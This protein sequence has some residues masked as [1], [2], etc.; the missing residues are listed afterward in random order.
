MSRNESLNHNRENQY[1]TK[2]ERRSPTDLDGKI[3][4]RFALQKLEEAVITA[5][6]KETERKGGLGV[7]VLASKSK[8]KKDGEDLKLTSMILN[9]FSVQESMFSERTKLR[10]RGRDDQPNPSMGVNWCFLLSFFL[11]T[12]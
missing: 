4:D 5:Q 7:S 9:C 3:F 6:L 10:Q 12:T 1:N 2:R 11:W 8:K